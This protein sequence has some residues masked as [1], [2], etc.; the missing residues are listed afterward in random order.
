MGFK[1]LAQQQMDSLV[2]D[3][4]FRGTYS[5]TADAA[6]F[7]FPEFSLRDYG[8]T[9]DGSIVTIKRFRDTNM[10]ALMAEIL[11]QQKGKRPNIIRLLDA[12]SAGD[13]PRF[14]F[15]QFGMRV[16]K[17][18]RLAPVEGK[19]ISFQLLGA[20]QYL[21]DLSVAHLDIRVS[22]VTVHRSTTGV[23][24]ASGTSV[25]VL[26]VDFA[27]S[28]LLRPG[29]QCPLDFG[30]RPLDSRAP[31]LLLQGPVRLNTDM[32]GGGMALARM[33][34]G[35]A[36]WHADAGRSI[37]RCALKALGPPPASEMGTLQS[38]PG[39]QSC[40]TVE[41]TLV[42]WASGLTWLGDQYS[43]LVQAC[44]RW[45]PFH[46]LSASKASQHP[47][48]TDRMRMQ[49]PSCDAD[50]LS[51]SGGPWSGPDLAARVEK[52]GYIVL[53]KFVG[54]RLC[55]DLVEEIRSRVAYL[56][57]FYEDLPY[58]ETC[59]SLLLGGNSS[60][61]AQMVGWIMVQSK[62]LD[63][64]GVEPGCQQLG[65]GACSKAALRR[66][67]LQWPSR[68]LSALLCQARLM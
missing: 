23:M 60:T 15:S 22:N 2:L 4:A 66:I 63:H 11:M 29:C 48:F 59:S 16:H 57:S 62:D 35:K 39:W 65:P 25:H 38:Y 12:C 10:L 20:I 14:V 61:G 7:K 8:C 1:F 33:G 21:H 45:T 50:A 31:E 64:A 43:S 19:D 55:D 6:E 68:K 36:M 67:R 27:C 51:G 17:H 28:R 44:L 24:P 5:C 30:T 52:E 58:D 47:F 46:R 53:P 26:L 42:E 54:E 13:G 3:Q 9:A 49:S 56:L 18:E 37:L 32:W 40:W 41:H 34:L